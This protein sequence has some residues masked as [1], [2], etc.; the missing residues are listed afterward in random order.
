MCII[1]CIV[2]QNGVFARWERQRALAGVCAGVLAGEER[3]AALRTRFEGQW[4]EV[5]GVE[6]KAV[7]V[8]RARF[9]VVRGLEDN[10][11]DGGARA[12]ELLLLLRREALVAQKPL[13]PVHVVQFDVNG[14]ALGVAQLDELVVAAVGLRLDIRIEQGA[15]A[16]EGQG[17]VDAVQLLLVQGGHALRVVIAVGKGPGNAQVAHEGGELID[18]SGVIEG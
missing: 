17:H 16:L 1:S 2:W 12:G 9:A 7:E 4:L 14:I 8:E 6:G 13:V 11:R 18:R 5:L 15:G 10:R 3:D